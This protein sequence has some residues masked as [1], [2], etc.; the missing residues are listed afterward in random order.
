[1]DEGSGK[2]ERLMDGWKKE[3]KETQM[4]GSGRKGHRP[5]CVQANNM[6]QRCVQ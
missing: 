2:K 5:Y 4:L 1:M 6:V 3:M